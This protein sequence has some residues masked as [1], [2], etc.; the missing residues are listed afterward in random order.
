MHQSLMRISFMFD[1]VYPITVH[2]MVYE[3]RYIK[4]SNGKIIFNIV[5]DAAGR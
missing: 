5:I 4:K 3:G 1:L 2:H